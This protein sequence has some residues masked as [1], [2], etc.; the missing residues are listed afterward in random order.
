[1]NIFICFDLF[2]C[3]FFFFFFFGRGGQ[4][5]AGEGEGEGN[6]PNRAAC[7]ISCAKS[8][9]NVTKIVWKTRGST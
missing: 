5:V 9:A 1:M 4:G 3:F 7:R 8:Y 6:T 2:A